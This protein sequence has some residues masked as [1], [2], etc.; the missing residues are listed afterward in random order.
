MVIIIDEIVDLMALSPGEVEDSVCRIA[1]QGRACGIHLVIATQNPSA[2]VITGNIKN[3]IPTR[4][5]FS[6]ASQIDSRKII[7]CGGAEDLTG[8]GDMLFVPNGMMS[9]RMQCSYISDDEV[10]AVVTYIKM[11]HETNYSPDVI[12][13][14]EYA[15]RS[16]IEMELFE[17]EYDSKLPEAVDIALDL[18]QAS[19]SMLQRKMRIGYARAGRILDEMSRRGILSEPNGSAPREV[20]ISRVQAIEMFEDLL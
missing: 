12:E 19:I 7:D 14:I 15:D 20:L 6:V 4:I 13:H 9:M 3:N 1:Q 16:G 5:A 17:A 10:R 11:S 2:N 8:N 18:G